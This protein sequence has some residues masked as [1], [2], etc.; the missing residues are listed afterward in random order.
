[1]L[2]YHEQTIAWD[3]F[4]LHPHKPDDILSV[5]N[6]NRSEVSR[7]GIALRLLKE[8]VGPRQIVAVGKRAYEELASLGEAST[9]VRHPSQGGKTAFTTAIRG[10]FRNQEEQ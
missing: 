8:Y 10:I 3:A 6:P 7:F 4:P 5:R 2:Q 1:M 9:Y